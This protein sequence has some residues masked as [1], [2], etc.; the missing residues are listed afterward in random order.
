MNEI[1]LV[2]LI[3]LSCLVGF[4]IYLNLKKTDGENNEDEE[5]L[6]EITESLHQQKDRFPFPGGPVPRL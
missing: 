1:I 5:M 6:N 3:L 4:N 2:L